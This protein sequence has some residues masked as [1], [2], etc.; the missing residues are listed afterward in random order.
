MLDC[1][2]ALSH[3]PTVLMG[4]PRPERSACVKGLRRVSPSPLRPCIL[5]AEGW[6]S[7]YF[8]FGAVHCV[9]PRVYVSHLAEQW[10]Y[11][12]RM[13]FPATEWLPVAALDVD[14]WPSIIFLQGSKRLHSLLPVSVASSATVLLCGSAP[15]SDLD[16]W[17]PV[18]LRHDTV[19]G[20]IDGAWTVWC[21]VPRFSFTAPSCYPRQLR[22]FVHTAAAVSGAL[23]FVPSPS[24]DASVYNFAFRL[25]NPSSR[26]WRGTLIDWHGLLPL[27]APLV[28]VRVPTVFA[29]GKWI[30]RGLTASEL[31][32]VFDLPGVLK[33]AFDGVAARGSLPFLTAVP[34]K[35]LLAVASGVLGSRG[36]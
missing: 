4:T 33:G 11:V 26:S 30:S 23:R 24:A 5:L 8:V 28:A 14:T 19:G 10:L 13:Q 15:G 36:G 6:P 22:H 34:T 32:D 12:L 1:P 16:R 18:M 35:I 21:N 20:A 3:P 17:T 7:W 29:P 27:V 25:S 9:C 31:C 2:L